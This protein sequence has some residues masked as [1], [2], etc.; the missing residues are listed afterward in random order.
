MHIYLFASQIKMVQI[1][2]FCSAVYMQSDVMRPGVYKHWMTSDVCEMMNNN[3]TD[4]QDAD[5][6]LGSWVMALAQEPSHVAL[7]T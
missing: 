3:L 6:R 5:M 4:Q 1:E 7:I 2:D